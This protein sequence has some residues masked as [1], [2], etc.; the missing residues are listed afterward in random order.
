MNHIS[1]KRLNQFCGGAS[2]VGLRNT[3][4]PNQS[5]SSCSKIIWI[6]LSEHNDTYSL[7]H[8]GNTY[9]LT[10]EPRNLACE[11]HKIPSY[12]EKFY[13]VNRNE[14]TGEISGVTEYFLIL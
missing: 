7:E 3:F 1:F 13:D 10:Y 11:F 12:F 5:L 4:T 6:T 8:N 2:V 14:H 9:L